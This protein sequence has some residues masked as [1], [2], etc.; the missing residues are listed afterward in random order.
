MLSR[1]M[2]VLKLL[3]WQVVLGS[4]LAPD[5]S[6]SQAH[7]RWERG[8]YLTSPLCLAFLGEAS[9][10]GVTA[11]LHSGRSHKKCQELD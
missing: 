6:H 5:H 8:N 2:K 10:V 1:E 7:S 3:L 9:Q 11:A 4:E